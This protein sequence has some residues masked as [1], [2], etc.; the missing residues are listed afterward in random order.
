MT[1]RKMP[2]ARIWFTKEQKEFYDTFFRLLGAASGEPDYGADHQLGEFVSDNRLLFIRL[3]IN[4]PATG[5]M[6]KQWYAML[7]KYLPG[8]IED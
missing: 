3:I 1:N 6:S 5:A 4:Q 7:D 8:W 2:E